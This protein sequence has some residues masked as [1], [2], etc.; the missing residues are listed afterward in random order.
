MLL[1]DDP[2]GRECPLEDAARRCTPGSA[3]LESESAS[4]AESVSVR[5]SPLDCL[6]ASMEY[7]AA[8]KVSVLELPAGVAVVEGSMSSTVLATT[9]GSPWTSRVPR[10][11]PLMPPRRGSSPR[12]EKAAA[13][14]ATALMPSN[15]ADLEHEGSPQDRAQA[16]EGLLLAD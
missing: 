4:M 11:M 14:T 3:R 2:V 10:A 13:S 16:A 1:N 6:H 8:Q 9:T 7:R 15:V 5:E 12:L